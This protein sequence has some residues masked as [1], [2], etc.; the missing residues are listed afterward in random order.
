MAMGAC[1]FAITA[2]EWRIQGFSQR[3]VGGIVGRQGVPQ[4]PEA[5]NQVLMAVPFNTQVTEVCE[6]LFRPARGHRFA[7]RQTPQGLRHFDV[8]E[9]GRVESLLRRQGPIGHPHALVGLQQE[10]QHRRSIDDNQRLSR[11]ARN[12][13]VGEMLPR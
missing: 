6:G 1:Q 8:D 3:N 13:S 7:M 4:L 5:C 9:M 2:Q 10:L 12:A 11:S